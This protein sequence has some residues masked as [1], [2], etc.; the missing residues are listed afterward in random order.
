LRTW[1]TVCVGLVGSSFPVFFSNSN[2]GSEGLVPNEACWDNYLI[3]RELSTLKPPSAREKS[4]NENCCG[5]IRPLDTGRGARI[6]Q[7]KRAG[8]AYTL[9]ALGQ[10]PC[11]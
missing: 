11:L 2:Y 5:R 7:N 10:S 3:S 9:P 1:G 4:H 6:L 8:N